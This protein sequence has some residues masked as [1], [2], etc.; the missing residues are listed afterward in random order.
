MTEQSKKKTPDE[1]KAEEDKLIN[2]LAEKI[3]E[4]IDKQQKQGLT[5]SVCRICGYQ[6][7]DQA[8]ED[9][10]DECPNCGNMGETVKL[11]WSK[12]KK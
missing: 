10:Y 9:K 2:R 5:Y 8:D 6:F 7:I 11:Q 4:I 3:V 12:N 1:V